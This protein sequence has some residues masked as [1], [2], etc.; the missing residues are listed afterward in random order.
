MSKSKW[1]KEAVAFGYR[2]DNVLGNIIEII[3]VDDKTFTFRYTSCLDD[4]DD[5]PDDY[6]T[7]PLAFLNLF[8]VR[9]TDSGYVPLTP[10]AEE[11]LA[12]A[13]ERSGS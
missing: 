3:D 10:A 6:V 9:E 8:A 4:G 5:F 13:R 1:P 11:M 12:I 2:I 7:H